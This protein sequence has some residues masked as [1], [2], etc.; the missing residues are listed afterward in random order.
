MLN[1]KST[2]LFC[3]IFSTALLS[4][5]ASSG[6]IK[7]VKVI[8]ENQERKYTLIKTALFSNEAVILK[9]TTNEFNRFTTKD[10]IKQ[11]I[12]SIDD[13]QQYEN[14]LKDS[15]IA[16]K[17]IASSSDANSEIIPKHFKNFKRQY[18]GYINSSGDTLLVVCFIDFTNKQKAKKFFFNWKYQQIYL[19]S[20]LYLDRK[21]PG[22]MYCYEFNK[23][24]RKL[25]RYKI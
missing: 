4:S 18:S 3:F 8:E 1:Y 22:G 11:Y 21:P 20:T 25:N 7:G 12:L 2:N 23:R 15:Y 16:N 24:T 14:I 13:V 19:G 5:C 6:Q 17:E 10:A 9:D